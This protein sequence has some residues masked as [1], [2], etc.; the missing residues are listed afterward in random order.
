MPG[1]ACLTS[2]QIFSHRLL[3]PCPY[4]MYLY[5]E[6]E[7]VALVKSTLTTVVATLLING[8]SKTATNE[9]TTEMLG[10]DASIGKIHSQNLIPA[11]SSI[12]KK[13]H[14]V[15]LCFQ[16]CLAGAGYSHYSRTVSL[17]EIKTSQMLV[18]SISSLIDPSRAKLLV[19]A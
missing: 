18:G 15:V 7:L 12:K 11:S 1:G 9:S 8:I 6:N 4:M 14:F 3:E 16:Q 13:P 5:D 17:F 19:A 10:R 2:F